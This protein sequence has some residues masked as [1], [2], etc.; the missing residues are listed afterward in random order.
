MGDYE[1]LM[2]MSPEID[3]QPT[4]PSVTAAQPSAPTT[5]GF[6]QPQIPALRSWNSTQEASKMIHQG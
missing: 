2:G 4:R 6:G 1:E 3:F 5:V